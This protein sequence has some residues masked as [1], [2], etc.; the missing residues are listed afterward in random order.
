MWG[1]I[2]LWNYFIIEVSLTSGNYTVRGVLFS[3]NIKHDPRYH[4][5]FVRRGAEGM[6]PC[7]SSCQSVSDTA[8]AV[9]GNTMTLIRDF[10]TWITLTT[11]NN[12][13]FATEAMQCTTPALQSTNRT[14]ACHRHSLGVLTAG[15]GTLRLVLHLHRTS[16]I[17]IGEPRWWI[18]GFVIPWMLSWGTF[19]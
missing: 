19:R 12:I 9:D 6:C 3:K 4:L 17:F 15:S 7:S 11:L 10:F 16:P 2:C 8:V 5:F 13:N 1:Q 18:A 14:N